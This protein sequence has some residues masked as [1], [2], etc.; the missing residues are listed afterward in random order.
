MV[1]AGYVGVG[2]VGEDMV[3]E[4]MVGEDMVGEDMVGEDMVGEDM[5]GATPTS[6]LTQI[7]S[8][9]VGVAP[10]SSLPHRRSHIFAPT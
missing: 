5:V 7:A 10:T 3:G 4:D 2:M 9:D 6:R 1:G 8:R